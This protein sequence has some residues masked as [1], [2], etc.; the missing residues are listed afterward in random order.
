ME[1]T[2]VHADMDTFFVSC[3]RLRDSR[4]NNIP[5]II[6]SQSD[7]GVVA[8]CSYESRYFG[9]RSAMPM[10]MAK[11]LCPQA[12]IIQG[13]ME[14]Y[15]QKSEEVTQ[16]MTENAP[17][18]EKASI[19]EFYMDVSGL[20]K[21]F[22]CYKWTNELI[23]KIIKETGLPMSFG[24]SVNKTVSK[25]ATGEGKPKGKLQVEPTMTQ[26]FIN[27]LSIKK[28]PMLG[29]ETYRELSRIGIR[30]IHNLAET[31]QE[32]LYRLFG[33]NGSSLWKKANGIDNTPVVPYRERKSLSTERTFEKDTTKI[34][35]LRALIIKMVEELAFDL[36]QSNQLAAVVTIKIRYS[37]FNTTTKQKTIPFTANDKTLIEIA[38]ELFNQAYERR[39]L[40]RLVGVR[41]GKLIYGSPQINLF[42]DTEEEIKLL[43]AIDRMKKRFGNQAITRAITMK[44]YKGK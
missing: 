10:Y 22:G 26:Q 40:I 23:E 8:S 44:A 31:P 27:P 3:E 37:D 35:E 13:D 20:D 11:K 33:E 7:R 43:Q 5:L 9:V 34:D 29:N 1:R 15:S 38:T 32:F 19:D 36:R 41:F 17:V 39:L 2:I 30:V 18:L 21:F 4:L 42:E 24:M 28:I 6:G 14:L 12:K 16:I 25:I